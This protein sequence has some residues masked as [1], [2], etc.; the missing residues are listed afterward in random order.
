MMNRF[1]IVITV[2]AGLS[3]IFASA[4]SR[5]DE[6]GGVLIEER[7][8]YREYALERYVEVYHNYTYELD[9]EGTDTWSLYDG[10]KPFKGDCEDFAFTLQ[11]QVG[12]GSVYSVF[13]YSTGEIDHA[14][15]VHLG[16]VWDLDGV[17]FELGAYAD[18]RGRIQYELGSFSP[19]L[20]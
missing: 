11:H 15:F 16:L 19:E 7:T 1:F 18:K 10:T 13:R 12:A 20:R 14:V 6:Q 4:T 5:A 17:V 9:E 3:L 2:L 8:S